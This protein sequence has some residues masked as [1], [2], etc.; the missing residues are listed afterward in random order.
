MDTLRAD[1]L[2]CLGYR[3]GLTP[4]LDAIAREGALFRNAFVSDIPTQ[5]SH[6]AIFTGKFGINS[7][8]VSH[9]HPPAKLDPDISWLPSLYQD[10]GYVTG[11]VDHLFAMKDWFERGYTHYMPPQGRSRA[12]G[13][14]IVDLGLR[15]LKDHADDN[16]FLFLHFWDAHIP[17]VPPSPFKERYTLA[18]SS[19]SDPLTGVKLRDRPTY[20]LFAQ[21]LYNHLDAVP[22][23]DY[24]ADLY[25]AEVAYLD[26][27]IGNLFD[28]LQ[29]AGILDN[30]MVVLFGDHGENM[31]EHDAWFDH[32]GLYDSVVHIPL[33]MWAPGK[34][35]ASEISTMVSLVDV[36]P[37]VLELTGLPEVPGLDGRSLVPLM[38]GEKSSHR[39]VVF[40]SECTW[41]AKRGVRTPRWKFIRSIDPGMYPREGIELYDLAADPYEQHS[42]AHERPDVVMQL[43]TLLDE[44][45]QEQLHGRPDPIDEVVAAGLPAV[46]RLQDLISD[47]SG[48]LG[49]EGRRKVLL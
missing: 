31:T 18:S 26:H 20:P 1:R 25:D 30:T 42:V 45:L 41:Q 14:V 10:A 13:S 28:Y 24:I 49:E 35:P 8:I 47:A 6:T 38:K 3:R 37:S 15:W 29:S 40:L 34:I 11:A 44:W 7:G 16:F 43:G 32:A 46:R 48:E 36:K 9:F 39:D 2:G 33:I 19:I 22:N 4:N 12:P 21:N 27:E 23:L 5:P 17:Y